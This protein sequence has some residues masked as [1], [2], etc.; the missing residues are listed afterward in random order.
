MDVVVGLGFVQLEYDSLGVSSVLWFSISIIGFKD[1]L[2]RREQQI[3]LI[4]NLQ[5]AQAVQV[6]LIPKR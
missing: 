6:T 3:S 2:G 4:K 1:I 5:D